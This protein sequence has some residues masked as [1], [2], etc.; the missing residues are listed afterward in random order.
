MLPFQAHHIS[1]LVLGL[2]A[3]TSQAL[4]INC[5]G[6]SMCG[7]GTDSWV[8]QNLRNSI[9]G[10]DDNKYFKSGDHIACDPKGGVGSPIWWLPW[11]PQI[12]GG[13]CA[14]VQSI[15]GMDGRTVKWLAKA[16]VDHK[17]KVCGSAPLRDNDVK[18]GQ[19]TFNYV[20]HPKCDEGI[21]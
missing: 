1:T 2:L 12:G 14:F 17:C 13:I 20:E 9:N 15:D 8:S 6:S 10:I 18:Y 3:T 5:R 7:V 21:C 11:I 19:L 16:I 4:G